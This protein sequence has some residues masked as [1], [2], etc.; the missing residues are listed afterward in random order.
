MLSLIFIQIKRLNNQPWQAKQKRM[1]NERKSKQMIV[2]FIR[3]KATTLEFAM[4]AAHLSLNIIIQ[5]RDLN[6]M[7]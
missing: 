6:V 1:A 2:R 7:L 5:V 4:R 3:L